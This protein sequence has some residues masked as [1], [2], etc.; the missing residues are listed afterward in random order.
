MGLNKGGVA[1]T[2]SASLALAAQFE[3]LPADR[4]AVYGHLYPGHVARVHQALA[5]L[6]LLNFPAP[7][8]L[9]EFKRFVV[10][11]STDR[12]AADAVAPVTG[13]NWTADPEINGL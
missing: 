4:V 2:I 11:V 1:E 5:G 6:R 9:P 12:R 3:E 8:P 10:Y 7:C 13:S